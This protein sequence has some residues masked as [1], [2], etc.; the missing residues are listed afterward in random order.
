[1][2]DPLLASHDAAVTG[3]A[4]VNQNKLDDLLATLSAKNPDV[5][6]DALNNWA[7]CH[8]HGSGRR[9]GVR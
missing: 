9:Q 1:M 4:E 8:Q 6:G 5:T 3:M 7:A 2:K